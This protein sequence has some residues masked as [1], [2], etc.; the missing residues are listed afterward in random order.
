[1]NNQLFNHINVPMNQTHLSNGEASD[2]EKECVRY[3]QLIDGLGGIDIQLLGVRSNGHFGF[4][5]PGTPFKWLT[6]LERPMP[7]CLKTKALNELIHGKNNCC[8]QS[9]I[10]LSRTK[11]TNFIRNIADCSHCDKTLTWWVQSSNYYSKILFL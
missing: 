10:K 6:P 1:M 5:E 8:R 3:E 2:L 4:N 11:K 7:V 9:G